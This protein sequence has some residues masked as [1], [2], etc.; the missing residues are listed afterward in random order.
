[1]SFQALRDASANPDC[2]VERDEAMSLNDQADLTWLDPA[3]LIQKEPPVL[4]DSGTRETETQSTDEPEAPEPTFSATEIPTQPPSLKASL[5]LTE[6]E[7]TEIHHQQRSS[8]VTFSPIVTSKPKTSPRKLTP[9]KPKVAENPK[10]PGP[11]HQRP[12]K[13]GLVMPKTHLPPPSKRPAI[14]SEPNIALK[15]DARPKASTRTVSLSIFPNFPHQQQQQSQNSNHN[16]ASS[17]NNNDQMNPIMQ[18]VLAPK[19]LSALTKSWTHN[20]PN[21]HMLRELKSQIIKHNIPR[22]QLQPLLSKRMLSI[23]FDTPAEKVLSDF[24]RDTASSR[25]RHVPSKPTLPP[26]ARLSKSEEQQNHSKKLGVFKRSSSTGQQRSSSSVSFKSESCCSKWASKPEFMP[27]TKAIIKN[28][29]IPTTAPTTNTSSS[30]MISGRSK[31]AIGNRKKRV[32]K[33]AVL[34]TQSKLEMS[35]QSLSLS[36]D[37]LRGEWNEFVGS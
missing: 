35:F 36:K 26:P 19:T 25:A 15:S 20:P 6:P 3:E 32:K 18:S 11:Q 12:S 8:V 23:I 13:T 1:M 9:K 28:K 7:K 27:P 21:V 2:H 14:K 22:A 16:N 31:G 10:S 37:I 5:P 33:K 30:S 34:V 4:T 29:G 17:K 24:M